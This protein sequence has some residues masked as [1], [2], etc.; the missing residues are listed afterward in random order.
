[1]LDQ[2][3][4]IGQLI[5]HFDIAA[6][7]VPQA[8]AFSFC[9][10]LEGPQTLEVLKSVFVVFLLARIFADLSPAFGDDLVG[11]LGAIL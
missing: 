5:G 2:R 10:R 3:I 8:F 1:M 9:L 4:G 7:G 11:Q 6:L